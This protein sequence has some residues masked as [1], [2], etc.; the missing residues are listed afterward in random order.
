LDWKGAIEAYDEAILLGGDDQI[1]SVLRAVAYFELGDLEPAKELL[2]KP[3]VSTGRE[4]HLREQ[5]K[6]RLKAAAPG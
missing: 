4:G 5:L 2:A 3:G 1:A 6:K